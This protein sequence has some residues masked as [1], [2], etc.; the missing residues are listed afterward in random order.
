MLVALLALIAD[1]TTGASPG[2]RLT[3]E[4]ASQNVVSLAPAKDARVR[5]IV[6]A[7]YDTGR[8]GLLHGKR[9]SRLAGARLG[10]RS[11]SGPSRS[12]PC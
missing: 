6:T 9:R 3:P 8:T 2:R 10:T 4:R 1:A 12:L 7:A 11:C 5:L